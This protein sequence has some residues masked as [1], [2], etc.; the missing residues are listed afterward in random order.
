[1]LPPCTTRMRREVGQDGSA[2]SESS[3]GGWSLCR[4]CACWYD[5]VLLS[6]VKAGALWPSSTPA[7]LAAPWSGSPSGTSSIEFHLVRDLRSSGSSLQSKNSSSLSGPASPDLTIV[8]IR[9]EVSCWEPRDNRSLLWRS[10]L[11]L[12]LS[13][14]YRCVLTSSCSSSLRCW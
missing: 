4:G 2:I 12:Q 11:L 3:M 14:I 6:S 9:L 10:S 8:S 5:T 1:M 13:T 7:L